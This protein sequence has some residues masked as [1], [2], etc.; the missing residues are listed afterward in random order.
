MART[1]LW[2]TG[3]L[4]WAAFTFWYTNTGGPLTQEEIS[5]YLS[6]MGQ[7]DDSERAKRLRSFLESD[8]GN[9]FIM[10]NIIDMAENPPDVPGAAPGESA[11]S[12][13]GRYM[14]FM[15]P[16][17]FSRACHPVFAGR[18]VAASLDL[19]GIEGAEVWDQG[20]LMRYRSRRDMMEIATNPEFADRHDFKI[21]ALDKTIAFPVEGVLNY[22]D[23]RFLLALLFFTIVSLIDLFFWR[24]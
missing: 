16:A 21:A 9:Q 18:A 7:G 8:T 14:A 13:L 3:L 20:A 12:L 17:L 6:R 11:Q 23:P 10:V 5:V 1:I 22:S 2:T 24:R 4:C 15:Y 19:T